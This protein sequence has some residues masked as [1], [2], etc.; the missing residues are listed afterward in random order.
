MT[1][2]KNTN[3]GRLN[4]PSTIF[5]TLFSGIYLT[6]VMA[7]TCVSIIMT[8]IV[9]SFF[10]RGPTLTHVPAWAQV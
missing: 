7:I 6:T 2:L 3:C 4:N 1:D 5:L 10:Y 9:L 8:V